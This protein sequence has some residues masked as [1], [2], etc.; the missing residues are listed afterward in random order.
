MS[1]CIYFVIYTVPTTQAGVATIQSS[2]QLRQDDKSKQEETDSG[3]FKNFYVA[4]YVHVATHTVKI[5][6]G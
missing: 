4:T 2:S 3:E 5:V 6:A 1:M